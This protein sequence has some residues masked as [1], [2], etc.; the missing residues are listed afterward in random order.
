MAHISLCCLSSMAP[1]AS[2]HNFII[3]MW[4]NVATISLFVEP[5]GAA[6]LSGALLFHTNYSILAV[7][8]L[9]FYT[10]HFMRQKQCLAN[11]DNE[12]MTHR[13]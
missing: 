6:V 7:V 1:V 5:N 10:C 4:V 12:S 8:S 3:L 9:C 13:Q 2:T 11:I